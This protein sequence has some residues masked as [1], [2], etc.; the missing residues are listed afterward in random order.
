M[1]RPSSPRRST[2]LAEPWR[3]QGAD[4]IWRALLR[5]VENG[6]IDLNKAIQLFRFVESADAGREQFGRFQDVHEGATNLS[7]LEDDEQMIYEAFS[8]I[9]EDDL[10]SDDDLREA[11]KL[12][13]RGRLYA[14]KR[15]KKGSDS[16]SE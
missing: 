12:K 7:D 15:Q 3:K 1:R 6:K 9:R 16:D 14:K 5:L 11:K 4:K 2:Y 13:S 10:G 8:P